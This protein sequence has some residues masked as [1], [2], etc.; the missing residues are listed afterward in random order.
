MTTRE[1][2]EEKIHSHHLGGLLPNDLVAPDYGGYSIDRIPRFIRMLFGEH[3]Q[4]PNELDALLPSQTKRVIF[5]ILD[6]MG[7]LH[8]NRLLSEFPDLFLHTLINRGTMVPLTSVFP[9]TTAAALA[10]LNTGLTPQEHAMLGYRLYLKE[11]AAITNMLSLSLLGN[12]VGDSALEAGI[13]VKTFLNVPTLLEQLRAL[14]VESHVLLSKHISSS[15]LSSLLY[16]GGAEMHPGVNLSDML[17]T[18]REILTRA[19]CKTFV[20]IYWGAT[21][22]IAHVRGPWTDHFAAELRSVDAALARELHGRLDDTVIIISADHG[23]MPMTEDDY[24]NITDY[25]LLFD[26]L[27]LPPVGDTRTGYLFVRDGRKEHVRRIIEETFADDVL[28]LDSEE[29]LEAGLFGTGKVRREVHDRIGDLIISSTGGK[30]LYYPYKDSA[31]LRG[32]HAG[33][34]PEEMLVPFIVSHL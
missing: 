23:F 33:L 9:S 4:Q 18:A 13:D 11:T 12:K 2:I 10:T 20:S 17:V 1:N 31:R 24:I 25:P 34:T 19:T 5:L 16:N 7:Y 22:T 28:C 3:T 29:A 27:L 6:G 14:E 30:A 8:L 21:D 32:M 15:G 26:S